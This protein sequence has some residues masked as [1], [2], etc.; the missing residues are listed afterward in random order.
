MAVGTDR[1]ANQLHVYS[2]EGVASRPRGEGGAGL[3]V[4]VDARALLEHK[5][6]PLHSERSLWAAR[7][8][9]GAPRAPSCRGGQKA[10]GGRGVASKRASCGC[11]GLPLLVQLCCSEAILGHGG[12]RSVGRRAGCGRVALLWRGGQSSKLPTPAMDSKGQ[13]SRQPSDPS[14]IFYVLGATSAESSTQERPCTGE[15]AA[16]IPSGTLLTGGGREES[17]GFLTCGNC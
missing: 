2:E 5:A 9:P 16:L 8:L 14:S 4:S 7:S 11:S 17:R 15:T 3:G 6:G 1:S 12:V 10:A 13:L